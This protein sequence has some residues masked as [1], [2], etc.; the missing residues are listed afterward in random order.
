MRLSRPLLGA[1]AVA[2]V[3]YGRRARLRT[4]TGTRALLSLLTSAS[5]VEAAEAGCLECVAVAGVTG[6]AAEVVGVATG[7]PFGRYRYSSLLGPRLA[8]VPL[9]AG[10]AW[11]AMARPAWVVAGWC[12]RRPAAR[13]VCAAGALTAWDVFVDPRM[14]RDGYW[15]WERTGRYEGVPASNFLGWFVT[16][17]AAFA[18]WPALAGRRSSPPADDLALAPPTDDLALALY[19]WTWLGETFANA[20]LWRRPVTAAAGSAAMG[21]FAAP[22]LARR[23]AR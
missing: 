18:A 1:V 17:L 13:V 10:A 5:A 22:A 8:G 9:L 21:A 23:Q 7:I 19:V 11:A 6:F 4:P 15:T 12:A 20:A 2:Q 16:G 3:V 14:V